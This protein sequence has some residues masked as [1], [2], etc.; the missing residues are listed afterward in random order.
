MLKALFALELFSFWS[1]H[2]GYVEK[3]LDKKT[4]VKFKI[5]DVTD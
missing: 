4:K 1:L 5:Y 2:F 3:W